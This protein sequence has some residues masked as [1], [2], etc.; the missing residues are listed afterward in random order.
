MVDGFLNLVLNSFVGSL[1]KG[2][3]VVGDGRSLFAVLRPHHLSVILL[4]GKPV[5]QQ[6]NQRLRR[7]PVI[8]RLKYCGE[9]LLD[10]TMLPW[11]IGD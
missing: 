7:L 6:H 2:E 4:V 11:H 8:T 9:Y 3:D 5:S 10:K 1:L